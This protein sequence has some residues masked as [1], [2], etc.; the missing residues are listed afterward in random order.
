MAERVA[1]PHLA[2]TSGTSRYLLVPGLVLGALLAE[3]LILPTGWLPLDEA[4]AVERA[5]GLPGAMTGPLYPLLLAP[6]ARH[7]SAQPLLVGGRVLG[8]VCWTALLVPAYALA[9]RGAPPRVA[10]AAAVL[11]VLVPGAVYAG[12]LTPEAVATLLAAAALVLEVRA[13]ERGSPRLLAA[14]LACSA[15]A[16][17]ARPW[18]AAL[19]PALVAAYALPRLR[20]RRLSPFWLAGGVA[21]LYGLF[22]GLGSASPELAAATGRPWTVLRDALGSAGAAAAGLGIAPVVLAGARL[23]LAPTTALL[24]CSGPALAFAAGL[25]AAGTGAGVDERPLL[26]LA[27]LVFALAAEAWSQDSRP[28]RVAASG[29]GVALLLAAVPWPAAKPALA[30]APG[31]EFSRE[32]IGGTGAGAAVLALLAVAVSALLLRTSSRAAVAVLAGVVVALVPGGELVAWNQARR[33]AD[34]LDAAL[35]RPRDWVDRATGSSAAVDV[36]A[37]PGAYTPQSLAELRIWNRSLRSLVLLDPSRAD[38]RTGALPSAGRGGLAL[39]LG[40][41]LAGERLAG[42]REGSVLRLASPLR[43]AE[44]VE[45][46]YPDGWS[47]ADVTYRRFSGRGATLRVTISRKAWGGPEVPG[48]VSMISSPIG[49]AVTARRDTVVRAGQEVVVELPVPPAPFAVEIHVETFSP[50]SFGL[51]DT[52]QL[53][54][55]LALDYDGHRVG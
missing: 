24:V 20:G 30:G 26:V 54:A 15:A 33:A 41:E 39:A 8:A 16:A 10:A 47:G 46:L 45:G 32:L 28:R 23:S 7:A 44:S 43:L 50:S 22:Y 18:L 4:A 2:A 53:G 49:G 21:A 42:R 36:L 6:L 1:A 29:A 31:L 51:A 14:A 55:Q 13:S 27:P 17:F 52:R 5:R 40:V 34:S 25:S 19:P 37:V 12:A 48:A 9:R 35:P 11:S 3:A 38:P